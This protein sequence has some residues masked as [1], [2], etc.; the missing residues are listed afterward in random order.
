MLSEAKQ[1]VVKNPPANA[2]DLGLI[3]G[4]GRSPGEGSDNPFQLSSLENP[5]DTGAWLATV[6]VT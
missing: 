3:S 4:S 1:S 5:K 6:C 2:G